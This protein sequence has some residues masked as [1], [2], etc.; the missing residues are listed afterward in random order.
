MVSTGQNFAHG[1][2]SFFELFEF[3]LVFEVLKIN[4]AN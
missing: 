3:S 1:T 4:H 2:E